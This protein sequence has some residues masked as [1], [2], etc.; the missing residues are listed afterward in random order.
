MIKSSFVQVGLAVL[1]LAPFFFGIATAADI[2]GDVNPRTGVLPE[3]SKPERGRWSKNFNDAKD[4]SDQTSVPLLIYLGQNGCHYCND[5]TRDA[6]NTQTFEE[7]AAEQELYMVFLR[8]YESEQAN[9]LKTWLRPSSYPTIAVY[10]PKAAGTVPQ[11]FTARVDSKP[12]LNYEGTPAEKL[13]RS[14]E[15]CIRGYSKATRWSFGCGDVEDDRLEAAASTAR[16]YVP[17]VRTSNLEKSATC[18]LAVAWPDGIVAASTNEIAWT[19]GQELTNVVVSTSVP[20]GKDFPLGKAI[21]LTLIGELGEELAVSHIT[22]VAE[23]GCSIAYPKWIGEP[24]DFGEWTMDY[25]AAKAKGGYVLVMFTGTLWCPFCYGCETSLLADPKFTEWAKDNDVALVSFDQ[26]NS[27]SPATAAGNGKARL[28]TYAAGESHIVT[29]EK[30][31]GAFYLSSKGIDPVAAEARIALTT[32]FTEEWL[33]PGST[34]ARLGNPTFLLVRNDKVVGRLSTVRNADKVYDTDENIARL[35][36]LLL[37]GGRDDE[38]ADYAV[39]TREELAVGIEAENTTNVTV[40]INRTA[41]FVLT[42][43]QSGVLTLAASN[44]RGKDVL[45]Q[46]LLDGQ[47]KACAT[48]APL[49]VKVTKGSLA[50]KAVVLVNGYPDK[51]VTTGGNSSYEVVLSARLDPAQVIGATDIPCFFGTDQLLQELIFEEEVASVTVRKTAGALPAGLR[52]AYDAASESIRLTG[53]PSAV[54]ESTFS[55]SYTIRY[56]SGRE[57]TG[58][59]VEVI[60]KVVDPSAANPALRGVIERTVPMMIGKGDAMQLVG[61]LAFSA[62]KKGRIAANFSGTHSLSFNGRWQAIDPEDGTAMAEFVRST[63][64][65]LTVSLNAEGTLT[66]SLDGLAD[67]GRLEGVSEVWN[68]KQSFDGCYTAVLADENETGSRLLRFETVPDCCSPT[69]D[70]IYTGLTADGIGFRGRAQLSGGGT[71]GTYEYTL[72][73]VYG[74]LMPGAVG[75]LTRIRGDGSGT[76]AKEEEPGGARVVTSDGAAK[77]Y[78][79]W[80]KSGV[81]LLGWTNLYEHLSAP[82]ALKVDGVRVATVEPGIAGNRV[83]PAEGVDLVTFGYDAATGLLSGQASFRSDGRRL[84]GEWRAILL[85]GWHYDCGCSGDEIKVLPFAMGSF[86]HK[87]HSN[88]TAVLKSLPVALEQ[89]KD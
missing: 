56:K 10:W 60:S 42:G 85:P 81:S 59:P 79:S 58:D 64:E 68:G 7:W 76:Y 21:E 80:Y 65:K 50:S 82:F 30:P 13:I 57:E 9:T 86:V 45:L 38:S 1:L 16:V 51:S 52:L 35:N 31:S 63:G 20:G 54:Q 73:P 11:K 27:S 25:E 23:R 48:N 49:S 14:I 53:H 41:A 5:L 4:L 43:R 46:Y 77:V 17:I 62:T 24:F 87:D 37:L 88:G 71:D 2:A 19:E 69:I 47:I 66:A 8:E 6:I 89:L 29:G 34:G 84:T 3:S 32:R 72:L 15:P 40:Q 70:A 44:T 74:K 67:F 28:L 39:S 36:D 75:A 61:T 12:M 83:I 78:G 18:R 26:G 22:F 33:M 55:Y